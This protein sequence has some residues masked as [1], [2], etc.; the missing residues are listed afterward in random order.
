[1]KLEWQPL[2][3]AMEANPSEWIETTQ[4]M[5]WDMLESVPPRAQNKGYISG[6]SNYCHAQCVT[7]QAFPMHI[8]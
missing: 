2:W 8:T 5:Y 1:M 7:H 3:D 6:R 4:K